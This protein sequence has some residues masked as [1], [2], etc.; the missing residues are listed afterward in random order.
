MGFVC[1]W[2]FML[3]TSLIY[4]T[5]SSYALGISL[6]VGLMLFTSLW[7][8]S[9][10]VLTGY[11]FKLITRL[12]GRTRSIGL[13][14]SGRWRPSLTLFFVVPFTMRSE[15][16]STICS[17]SVGLFPHSSN[18]FTSIVLH[19]TFKGPCDF[20]STPDSSKFAQH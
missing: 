12:V 1:V 11:V 18:I 8:L 2:P 20:S 3:S 19:S 15:G 9:W 10:W 4:R 7:D 14:T 6:V 13:V 16:D 17:E 5:G